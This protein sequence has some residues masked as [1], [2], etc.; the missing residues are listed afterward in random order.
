MKAIRVHENGGPEVLK[1]AE[2]PLPIPGSG[3]A[4][5]RISAVGVNF[6]EVYFRTGAY[7]MS[8]PFIPGGEAAGVVDA[9]GEGVTSFS[10]GDRVASFNF[11][12]SYADYA[13]ARAERLVRLPDSVSFEA[14]AA[15]MIQGMTAHYLARSTYRLS[16]SDTCLVHAAAGGVG[17]VLCQIA[18]MSGA[19]VIGTASTPEKAALARSAGAEDVILYTEVDFVAEARRLTSG[20]GFTVIYDSVGRSTF[21]KGLD[22]L[23]PRGMM[24]L[25]GQSSGAV[26]PIDPQV[27]NQKGSIFLTRPSLFHYASSEKELNERAADVLGWI[28]EGKVWVRAGHRFPLEAAGEAHQA[29]EA[30]STTGKIVLNP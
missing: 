25:Y 15:A 2:S 16:P 22:L 21:E 1:I 11:A 3:E 26:A 18:R 12:G 17:L 14:G 27:L 30:R 6:I 24:V 28:A 8:L 29:L 10:P 23:V 9:V 5:V 20:K 13:V 19:R 4:R 7:K